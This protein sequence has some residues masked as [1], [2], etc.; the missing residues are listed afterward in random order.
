[1]GGVTE[2]ASGPEAAAAS[3]WPPA[4]GTARVSADGS[5]LAFLSSAPL[6]G[7]DNTDQSTGQPDT[8]LFLWRAGAGLT[9]VSCNPTNARPI[10]PSSI[11]GAVA[12]G[13][14]RVYKPRSLVAGGS[15]LFFDSADALVLSDTNNAPDVYE[16]EAPGLGSCASPGG[17]LALVSSGK[18][19]DGATFADSSES[20][21]DAYF[22]TGQSLIRSDPGSVD[23]YDA[24]EG[25]GFPES[26]VPIACAGD[27][28]QSLP[29]E[30]DDPQPGTLLHGPGNPEL[31]FPPPR[32][33]QGKHR[34]KNHG[35]YRCV[36]HRHGKRSGSGHRR[37]GS[38]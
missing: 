1:G 25:G 24:R 12:N 38:R 7:Y 16:W 5:V 37:R 30:P 35:R 26:P 22:L 32:C 11:P 8:E 36:P 13:S 2:I 33:P 6:T 3:N 29:S 31:R 18:A 20:G 21:A 28:C 23:L 4:T 9:C 19:E 10:G 17:C 14:T 15:R 34:V 27:A